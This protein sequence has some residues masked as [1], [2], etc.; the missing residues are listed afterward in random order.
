M[1]STIDLLRAFSLLIRAKLITKSG[2]WEAFQDQIPK[3]VSTSYKHSSECVEYITRV[4]NIAARLLP[5]RTECLERSLTVC[6]MLRRKGINSDLCIGM[7]RVPPLMFHAW[8]EVD[9][10]VVNDTPLIKQ[11]FLV[12]CRL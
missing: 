12:I 2:S 3:V 5:T 11:S 8:V 7:T 10:Q 1:R 6:S 4:C 9:D